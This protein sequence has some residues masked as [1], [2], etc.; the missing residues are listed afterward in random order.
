M[1][2]LILILWL[3]QMSQKNHY[4]IF[5]SYVYI[6]LSNQNGLFH[7]LLAENL[8]CISAQ[9]TIL[10]MNWGNSIHVYSVVWYLWQQTLQS[11]CKE[12]P[13]FPILKYHHAYI[14]QRTPNS[15]VLQLDYR[16][17]DYSLHEE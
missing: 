2:C 13:L 4:T 16:T 15:P 6:Y 7:I 1:Y 12:K 11:S 14:E 8:F 10:C 9:S 3:H 17:W 5:S